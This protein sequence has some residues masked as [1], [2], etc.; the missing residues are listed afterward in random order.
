M[1]VEGKVVL[2][3]Y[4]LVP[5]LFFDNEAV[6]K[7]HSCAISASDLVELNFCWQVSRVGVA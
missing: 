1:D 6:L 2:L 3:A 5:G 4:L 7:G